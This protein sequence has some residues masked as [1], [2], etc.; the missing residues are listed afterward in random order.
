[1]LRREKRVAFIDA[2]RGWGIYP[3]EVTTLS[4][5]SLLW[6][7]PE[8][9]CHLQDKITAERKNDKGFTAQ[10][11]GTLEEWRPGGA[12]RQE[13]FCR[14]I[15]AQERL[16]RFLQRIGEDADPHTEVLPGL[17]LRRGASF[18]VDNMRP[19]R[20]IGSSGEFFTEMIVEV[21]QD[22]PKEKGEASP[23]APLRGGAT[24]IIDLQT[25]DIRYI[26]YKRIWAKLPGTPGAEHGELSLRSQRILNGT[27]RGLWRG[28]AAANLQ[29]SLAA[30]YSLTAGPSRRARH[31]PFAFLHRGA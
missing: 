16:Y 28:E 23:A 21:T 26:I 4:E 1:M 13:V 15:E 7:G 30:T 12:K 24:L 9:E 22:G 20:R 31:E 29:Q 27:T 5:E 8:K 11:A 6:R 17:D 14:V 19:A 3:R 2:F 10:L 25:W 18:N